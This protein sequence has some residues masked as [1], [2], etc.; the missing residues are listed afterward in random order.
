MPTM[1]AKVLLSS[2][3]ADE[4]VTSDPVA[5]RRSPCA[6]VS[7]VTLTPDQLTRK[8]NAYF[9]EQY[10]NG[11]NPFLC[12]LAGETGFDSLSQMVNHARRQGGATMRSISRACLAVGASYEERALEGSSNAAKMLEIIPQFDTQNTPEQLPTFPFR[13]KQEVDVNITGIASAQD[14]GKHLTAQEAYLSLIKNKTYEEMEPEVL[15]TVEGEDGEFTVL[16][17]DEEEEQT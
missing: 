2:E 14:K 13:A 3:E 7:A 9:E 17:I 12:D 16:T 6:G 8:M 11:A 5:W 1:S 10:D 4:V 15:E